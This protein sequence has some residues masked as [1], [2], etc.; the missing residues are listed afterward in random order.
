VLQ[1]VVSI[2]QRKARLDYAPDPWRGRTLEW[3]TPSPVPVYNFAKLPEVSG[4]DAFW[5]AKHTKQVSSDSDFMDIRLP[6]NTPAGLLVAG[7]AFLAGF[8]IIWHIWTLLIIGGLGV[9][10]SII[11]RSTAERT[12][13]TIPAKQVER[14][15]AEA[16][17]RES[18]A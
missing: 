9:L 17:A 14:I 8:G 6:K 16:R 1:F 15:E 11:L 5:A 4:R 7:F 18:Y 13:Y 2:W 3:A 10:S 12:E